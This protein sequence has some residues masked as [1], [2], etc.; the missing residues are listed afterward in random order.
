MRF[1]KININMETRF[2]LLNL[3]LVIDHVME[4]FLNTSLLWVVL[5]S[6]IIKICIAL[7]FYDWK[8]SISVYRSP[9]CTAEKRLSNGEY[10]AIA[11]SLIGFV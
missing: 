4:I 5:S 6:K 10:F 7:K 8:Y 9:G 2:I 11:M 3:N 1:L